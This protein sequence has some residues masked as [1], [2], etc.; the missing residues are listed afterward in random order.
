MGAFVKRLYFLKK[1]PGS[2]RSAEEKDP[3]PTAKIKR[4]HA[5]RSRFMHIKIAMCF[6]ACAQL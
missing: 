6:F 4:I 5:V 1:A 3:F 2:D